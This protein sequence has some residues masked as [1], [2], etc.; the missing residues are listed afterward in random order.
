MSDEEFLKIYN[1]LEKLDLTP[2]E[3]ISYHSRLKVIRDHEL[4]LIHAK[5]VGIEK[6]IEMGRAESIE[7]GK[8]EGKKAM[9]RNGYENGIDIT[10]M[11]LVIGY[12]EEEVKAIIASFK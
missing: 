4:S 10:T 1:T 7:E 11:A 12:S 6:G 8:V 9:I 2:E 3:A 5:E